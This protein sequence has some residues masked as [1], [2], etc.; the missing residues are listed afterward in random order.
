MDSLVMLLK[1]PERKMGKRNLFLFCL[2]SGGMRFCNDRTLQQLKNAGNL[3][4]VKAK[5]VS[6]AIMVVTSRSAGYFTGGSQKHQ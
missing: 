1:S 5:K 3:Q 4:L 6:D 2:V